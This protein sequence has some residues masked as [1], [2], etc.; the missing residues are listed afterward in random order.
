MKFIITLLIPVFYFCSLVAAKSHN[1]EVFKES[2]HLTDTI[3][4]EPK[5]GYANFYQK[6]YSYARYTN[7]AKKNRIT[8]RVHVKFIVN[9]N[10]TLSDFEI[11]KSLGY[12]LDE[13]TIEAIK[14]CGKWNA[15][16]IDGKLAKEEMVMPFAFKLR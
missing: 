16:K 6:W 9:E 12:G 3:N 1:N 2:L 13:I 11:R 7:E 5:G 4:A 8:G 15:K 10:G 14:K